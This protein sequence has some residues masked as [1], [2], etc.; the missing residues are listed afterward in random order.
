L[1]FPLSPERNFILFFYHR[2]DSSL[3]EP[4]TIQKSLSSA[5]KSPEQKFFLLRLGYNNRLLSIGR[6]AGGN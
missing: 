1:A 5:K 6:N 2:N 4:Y 3:Q